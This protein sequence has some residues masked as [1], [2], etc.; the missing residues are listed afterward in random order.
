MMILL[1]SHMALVPASRPSYDVPTKKQGSISLLAL[2][3]QHDPLPFGQSE[4]GG[5]TILII[6]LLRVTVSQNPEKV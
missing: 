4:L 6:G 2:A 1:T 3:P 5:K